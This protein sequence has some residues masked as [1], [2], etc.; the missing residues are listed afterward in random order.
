MSRFARWAGKLAVIPFLLA[1]LAGAA[2]A[3]GG[4]DAATMAKANNPL[5]DMNAVNLQNYYSPSLYGIP[6]ATSNVMNLRGVAVAGRH[7]V[8]ATLPVTTVPTGPAGSVSGLGDLNVF[9]AIVL[10]GPDSPTTA[11]VGPFW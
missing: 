3:Q 9:D 10:T 11:G 6:D 8:R 5:A 1:V 7:I 2:G 4:I